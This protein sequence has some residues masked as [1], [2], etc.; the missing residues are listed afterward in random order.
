MRRHD[1]L[2]FGGTKMLVGEELD[3]R[4]E[5]AVAAL[6]PGNLRP[7]QAMR[8]LGFSAIASS[9]AAASA[10]ARAASSCAS[11]LTAAWRAARP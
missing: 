2:A 7:R 1:L 6:E 8:P 10:E 5:R 9:R 3:P 11:T 4:L